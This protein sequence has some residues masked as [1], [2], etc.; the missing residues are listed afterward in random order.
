MIVHWDFLILLNC[1]FAEQTFSIYI[2]NEAE[3]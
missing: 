2:F 3:N 1:S